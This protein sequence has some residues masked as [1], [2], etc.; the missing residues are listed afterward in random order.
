LE[1]YNCCYCGQFCAIFDVK[2]DTLPKRS[3]DGSTAVAQ[4]H[5]LKQRLREGET[6]RIQ[7]PK[8]IETQFRMLCPGCQLFVAY[9]STA[10]AKTAKYIYICE[11]ALTQKASVLHVEGTNEL[12]THVMKEAMV[13]KSVQAGREKDTVKLVIRATTGCAQS[14]LRKVTD[15]GVFVDLRTPKDADEAELNAELR[16]HIAMVLDKVRARL[17]DFRPLRLTTSG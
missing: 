3:T 11:D 10:D 12:S 9:R 5:V 7:R 17:I 14:L 8:G 6:K 2:L 4:K 1:R 16:R 13:P 15:E